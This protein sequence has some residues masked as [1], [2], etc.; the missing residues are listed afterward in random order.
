[1]ARSMQVSP[2]AGNVALLTGGS[3]G[4][5]AGIAMRLAADG[6]TSPSANPKALTQ[7]RPLSK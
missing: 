5:G 1:M 7:R 2:L 6:A 3:R 4:I